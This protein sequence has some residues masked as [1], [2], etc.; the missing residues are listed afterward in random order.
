MKGRGKGL[1]RER[2]RETF[3]YFYIYIYE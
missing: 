1:L 3:K 2:G